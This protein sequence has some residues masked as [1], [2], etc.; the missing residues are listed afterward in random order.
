MTKNISG[1]HMFILMQKDLGKALRFY[2][3]IGAKKL[4]HIT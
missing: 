4:L 2:E 1:I 3:Q